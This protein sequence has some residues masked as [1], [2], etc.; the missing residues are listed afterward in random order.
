MARIVYMPDPDSPDETEVAGVKFT[1][2]EPTDIDDSRLALIT[3][4]LGNPWF[5]QPGD[6]SAARQAAWKAVRDAQ[7]MAAQHLAFAQTVEAEAREK[8]KATPATAPSTA[9]VQ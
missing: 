1:A 4:L 6:V 7:A 5:A 3:R 9:T 8:L 2:Y